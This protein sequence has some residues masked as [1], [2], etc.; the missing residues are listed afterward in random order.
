MIQEF[1]AGIPFYPS[2]YDGNTGVTGVAVDT[3]GLFPFVLYEDASIDRISFW[4][5]ATSTL[6]A[7]SFGLF[8]FS[9]SRT[10]TAKLSVI[11]AAIQTISITLT[12]IS[13]GGYWLG[14]TETGGSA[15]YR[16]YP[17]LTSVINAFMN[18]TSLQV[19][20]GG[21]T[22]SGDLPTSFSTLTANTAVRLPLVRFWNSAL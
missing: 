3:L 14:F 19:G 4:I 10:M 22:A 11:S 13:A 8:N 18:S 12:T 1:Y 5:T 21:A 2:K 15:T 16:N 6:T 7:V 20:T 9:K 17:L